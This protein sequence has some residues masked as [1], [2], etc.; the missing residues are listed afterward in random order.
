MQKSGDAGREAA[1]SSLSARLL[2]GQRTRACRV[3]SIHRNTKRAY[4]HKS[5]SDA[6]DQE[7]IDLSGNEPPLGYRKVYDRLLGLPILIVA[8]FFLL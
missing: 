1:G 7:V 4:G 3:L 6:L 2:F 5:W 8:V